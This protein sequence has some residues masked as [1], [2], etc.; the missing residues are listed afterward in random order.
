MHVQGST[1][2]N[3]LQGSA[4]ISESNGKAGPT[5]AAQVASEHSAAASTS[6]EGED[7]EMMDAEEPSTS[8]AVD[9]NAHIGKLT[10]ECA[11]RPA[12]QISLVRGKKGSQKPDLVVCIFKCSNLLNGSL[13]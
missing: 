7:V 4:S 11:R 12:G 9:V 10:G 2:S 6:R 3:K 13:P 5:G 8:K 1:Q